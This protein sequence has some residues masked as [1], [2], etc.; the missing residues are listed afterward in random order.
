MIIETSN[1]LTPQLRFIYKPYINRQA[2][3]TVF[4]NINQIDIR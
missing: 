1:T 2:Q 3:I 4:I